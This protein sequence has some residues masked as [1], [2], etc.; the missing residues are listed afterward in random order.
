MTPAE[1]DHATA[2]A[3][4]AATPRNISTAEN[5]C[6]LRACKLAQGCGEVARDGIDRG[7]KRQDLR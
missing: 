3:N 1:S 4:T 5:K 6:W 7:S 2:A